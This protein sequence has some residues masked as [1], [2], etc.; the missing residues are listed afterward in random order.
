MNQEAVP[1]RDQGCGSRRSPLRHLRTS[2]FACSGPSAASAADSPPKAVRLGSTGSRANASTVVPAVSPPAVPLR[3]INACS[4][5]P[6]EFSVRQTLYR[7]R[8]RR[9]W[10]AARGYAP[11]GRTKTSLPTVPLYFS[12]VMST[13]NPAYSRVRKL[14]AASIK[15]V[16]ISP[17]IAATPCQRP[18]AVRSSDMSEA[19][20]SKNRSILNR[21]ERVSGY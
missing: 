5:G 15:K 16:A 4:L 1:A 12:P 20:N 19:L 14:R 9:S 6:G 7:W 10:R 13:Q 21:R 17:P 3:S 18:T 11:S 8:F 2:T